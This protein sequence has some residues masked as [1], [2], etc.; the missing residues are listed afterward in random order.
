MRH[1]LALPFLVYLLIFFYIPF[2]IVLLYS[3][4]FP[5]FTLK[6]YSEILDHLTLKVFINSLIL[7]SIT[8]ALCLFLAYPVSYYIA[9]KAGKWKNFLLILVILPFWISFLLR[10]YAIMTLLTPLGLMFTFP[11]VVIGMVYDYLPFM[12]LPLYAS[13]ERLSRSQIDASYVLGAKP[14]ETFMRV[15]LPLSKPGIIAGIIL[16][17]IPA[18]GEFVVP[19]MLGGTYATIGTITWDLFLRYHNWWKGSALSVVYMAIV[20]FAI[21]VYIKRSG[22][23]EL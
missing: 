15:T 19:A 20:L 2:L 6:Y 7:A 10:T 12:I 9:L 1:F 4:G 8:T 22:R 3:F 14:Y 18:L 11:A 17:F 21:T 16:V 5:S 23:I 13:L